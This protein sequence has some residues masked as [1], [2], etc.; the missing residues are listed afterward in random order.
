METS[1]YIR[2]LKADQ[3]GDWDMA[4]DL[5]QHLPTQEA[6]WI[7]AYLHRKEGDRWN[8][9]YWY[10][11]AGKPYFDGTLEEEWNTIYQELGE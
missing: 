1:V 5:I 2:A 6:A 3:T 7:H 8:A 9:Q 4:H 10:D 11:R